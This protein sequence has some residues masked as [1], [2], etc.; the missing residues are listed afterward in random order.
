LVINNLPNGVIL[1]TVAPSK[2]FP[3]KKGTDFI[4]DQSIGKLDLSLV[5]K[6]KHIVG[7]EKTRI[8]SIQK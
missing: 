1:Q 3:L 2:T 7:L 4:V 8:S 6:I 5:K